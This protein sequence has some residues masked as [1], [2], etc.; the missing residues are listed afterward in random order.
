MGHRLSLVS[1]R[2]GNRVTNARKQ[3]GSDN[4]K[5]HSESREAYSS[6]SQGDPTRTTPQF[7]AICSHS[8]LQN[9][10]NE[11]LLE[12][13]A[14][15]PRVY[16]MS[17]SYTNSY[18]RRSLDCSITKVLG[19]SP[20]RELYC[21]RELVLATRAFKARRMELLCLLDQDGL[22]H[23]DQ[24]I[25]SACT[26]T[27]WKSQFTTES[28]DKGNTERKCAGMAGRV[29][30]CPH[31]VL[32]YE[33]VHRQQRW[34]LTNIPR[35]WGPCEDCYNIVHV[36]ES[37]SLTTF[38]ILTVSDDSDLKKR[39]VVKVLR[40]LHAPICPHFRLSSAFVT[41]AYARYRQ[42]IRSDIEATED[43]YYQSLSAECPSCHAAL[44]FEEHVMPHTGQRILRVRVR[45]NFYTSGAA[46]DS[47][48]TSQ[49]VQPSEFRALE[50]AWKDTL[51]VCRAYTTPWDLSFEY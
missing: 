13:T 25:C 26:K 21:C 14:L 17:L 31:V 9:L 2:D 29:W 47:A 19:W 39:K 35:T 23:Q 12:I 41:K 40:G 51:E 33:Q 27:H 22:I 15:L 42:F 37:D 3:K 32:S 6:Q 5:P 7:T 46:T 16:L 50:C 20:S 28:I 34:P 10:P 4:Q 24:M 18:F 11:L 38:P 43:R 45:R 8:R 36:R 30:L 44:W 1:S 48:W 49:L